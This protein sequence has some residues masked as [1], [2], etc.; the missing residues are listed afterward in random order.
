LPYSVLGIDFK[1]HT[2]DIPGTGEEL[3]SVTDRE[4]IGRYVAAVLGHPAATENKIIRIAGDTVTG[5]GLL[6]LYET[7]LGKKFA[8]SYKPAEEIERVSEEGLKSGDLGAYFGN[9]IP[10]FAATGV[11][12]IR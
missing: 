2:A 10:L 7:R 11:G 8:V 6:K 5:N 4:D 9:R 1:G 12:S 3:T